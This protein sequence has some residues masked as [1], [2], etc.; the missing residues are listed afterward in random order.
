MY[1]LRRKFSYSKI[2]LH[3]P[4]LVEKLIRKSS[5]GK[6]DTVLEIG[7]GKGIITSELIKIAGK[8]IAVELDSKLYQKLRVK[9]HNAANLKIYQGNFLNFKLP[10]GPYKVFSNLPFN[11]TS[12]VI[13]KLTADEN[14]REGYL[15]VQKEAAKRFIGYPQDTKNSM[16]SLL[17]K[18][19][20]DISNYWKFRRSDFVPQPNVDTLMIRI[21]RV[22]QPLVDR[23]NANL[24]RDFVVYNYSRLN[25][26]GL[27]SKT[28]LRK[29][30]SF[31]QRASS[32]EKIKV[33][34]KAGEYLKH[35]KSFHKIE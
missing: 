23:N 13:R 14:F 25:F 35:Q 2:F 9:F 15:I 33:S 5:I 31:V 24:Y 28:I 11:I 17:L 26:A 32:K 21:I 34:K 20:F 4:K 1:R 16:V 18:P 22:R 12:S 8:V 27:D 19:W 29:F 6:K 30:E 3:D 10:V 7:S